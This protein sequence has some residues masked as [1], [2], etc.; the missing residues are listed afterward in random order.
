MTFLSTVIA[1]VVRG[2]RRTRQVIP[3]VFTTL[4]LGMMGDVHLN[5]C[6]ENVW[7]AGHLLTHPMLDALTRDACGVQLKALR[8]AF[9][10]TI[11]Q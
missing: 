4:N 5:Y 8:G 1:E 9:M 11:Y 6:Q 2:V 3:G 10:M 7:I